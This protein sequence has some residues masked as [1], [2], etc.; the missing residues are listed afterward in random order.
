MTK[1]YRRGE[2]ET[3]YLLPGGA[4]GVAKQAMTYG[5]SNKYYFVVFCSVCHTGLCRLLEIGGTD[6]RAGNVIVV[7]PCPNCLRAAKEGRE[8]EVLEW[9]RK[10]LGVLD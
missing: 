8:V 4:E 10:Y 3:P 7:D 2:Q 1:Y 6:R 9:P 5:A